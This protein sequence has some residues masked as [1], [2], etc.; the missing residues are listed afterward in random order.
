MGFE[1]TLEVVKNSCECDLVLMLHQGHHELLPLESTELTSERSYLF[2]LNVQPRSR[3]PG[4]D[5]LNNS[6]V[7]EEMNIES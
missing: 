2:V 6:S 5:F 4:D 3:T 7:L 1:E